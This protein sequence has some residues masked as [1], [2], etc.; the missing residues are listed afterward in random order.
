MKHRPWAIVLIA[1]FHF[2]APLG[3]ALHSAYL[4]KIDLLTYFKALYTNL[5]WYQLADFFGTEPLTGIALFMMKAWSYPV[6]I[7]SSGWNMIKLFQ[8]WRQYPEN[9]SLTAMVALYI[10]NIAVVSYFLIPQVR[11]VFFNRRMRWWESKPRYF[12]MIPAVAEAGSHKSFNATIGN[13]SEGGLFLKT[14]QKLG[15]NETIHIRFDILDRPYELTGAV[16]HQQ[17]IGD[18]GYGIQF[19][20]LHRTSAT[21][22]KALVRALKIIGIS[23]R[24][25]KREVT[26]DF[27]K[28]ITQLVKTGQ[29]I[30]PTPDH[31][32]GAN[33]AKKPSE[34]H[35]RKS[36]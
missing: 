23:N 30:V 14:S 34:K 20:N 16:V 12:V 4:L 7:A 9:F 36:A 28:W 24:N 29:G 31:Y 22:M 13:L 3:N 35:L 19:T 25:E 32:N 33:G 15:M 17:N 11:A 21:E 5:A 1:F 8:T 10:F 27:A 18:P 2:L 26:K 6:F